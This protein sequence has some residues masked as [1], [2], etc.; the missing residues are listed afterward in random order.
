MNTRAFNVLRNI[1]DECNSEV[2]IHF[3]KNELIYFYCNYHCVVY[4]WYTKYNCGEIDS[5]KRLFKFLSDKLITMIEVNEVVIYNRQQYYNYYLTLLKQLIE[6][7]EM[8]ARICGRPE[9]LFRLGFFERH[10]KEEPSCNVEHNGDCYH[11]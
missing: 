9:R 1:W 2:I 6:K 10:L 11:G 7:S 3:N 5:Q 4:A 8:Y